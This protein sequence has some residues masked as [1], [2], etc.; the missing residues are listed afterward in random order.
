MSFGT[1]GSHYE[2]FRLYAKICKI[3]GRISL[4]IAEYAE[5]KKG[6]W[7]LGMLDRDQNEM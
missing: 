4:S 1:R 7:S 6:I 5:N 3:T 2:I